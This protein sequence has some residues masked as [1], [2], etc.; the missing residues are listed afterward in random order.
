MKKPV[1]LIILDGWGVG[2][3]ADSNALHVAPTPTLEWIS[4]NYPVT[5]LEASGINVGLPWGEA[6]NSEVGHLTLGA[7]KTLYQYYPLISLAIRDGSFYSRPALKNALDQ[8]KKN[9]S[10]LHL[11]GLISKANTHSS[12]EHI[13]ALL[14]MAQNEGVEKVK[15]HVIA[16]G[17]DTPPGSFSETLH[18]LPQEKIATAIGRYYALDRDENW[19]LTRSAYELLALGKGITTPDIAAS[20]QTALSRIKSEQ[21]LPA[22]RAQDDAGIKDG[23]SLIFFNFRGDSMEQL[24][25]P[26][27]DPSFSLF[28][29]VH[30]EDLFVATMA[31]YGSCPEERC[32]FLPDTVKEPLGKVLADAGLAQ[33]RLAETYRYSHVTKYFNGYNESAYPGEFR[34]IVPSTPTPHPEKTPALQTPAVT[35]RLIQAAQGGGFAFILANFPNADTMA[36]AGDFTA[37]VAAASEIDAQIARI[38]K[39][40]EPLAP[41]I[42]ITSDHGNAEIMFDSATGRIQTGHKKSPVPFYLIGPEFRGKAFFNSENLLS[43]TAGSLSDVAPTILELLGVKKPE[44]MTGSSLLISLI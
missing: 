19:A 30:Y 17:I 23:D 42:I 32:A 8:A 38:L 3:N 27:L 44:S 7:G 16:D 37:T 29:S 15:I 33:M 26:F 28:P 14:K 1:I 24:A 22:L 5:S 10:T 2:P 36:H 25:R 11:A 21:F 39:A 34:A 18:T 43:S 13:Q 4:K 35:D 41:Y 12:L 9:G 20:A 40:T 31:P 6:G